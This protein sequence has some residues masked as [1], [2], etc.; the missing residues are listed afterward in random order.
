MFYKLWRENW[1]PKRGRY[2]VLMNFVYKN[3]LKRMA[4]SYSRGFETKDL[5]N[6]KYFKSIRF[7]A[8]YDVGTRVW[9]ADK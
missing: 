2:C 1:I 5:L 7:L 4:C 8:F 6:M 3:L 9:C